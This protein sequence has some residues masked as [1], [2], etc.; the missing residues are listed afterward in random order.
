MNNHDLVEL[1]KIDGEIKFKNMNKYD[2]R[3]AQLENFDMTPDP[4]PHWTLKEILEQPNALSR[5]LNYGGRIENSHRVKL[6]GLNPDLLSIKNLII[7]ACGTS[8][9]A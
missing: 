8:L 1:E 2:L 6:G 4:Y 5:V 9:Y 7:S 3:K